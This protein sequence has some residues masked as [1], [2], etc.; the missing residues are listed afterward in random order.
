MTIPAT[1]LKPGVKLYDHAATSFPAHRRIY[2]L[3]ALPKDGNL[4][5]VHVA[6]GSHRTVAVTSP[7]LELV[8]DLPDLA[9]NLDCLVGEHISLRLDSGST[10]SGYCT[11]IHY[12]ST[13]VLGVEQ[14]QVESVELDHSGSSTFPWPTILEC[15][16]R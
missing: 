4:E 2:K 8:P 9:G 11:G 16:I 7:G 10:V 3:S 14:R 5:L 1:L 15:K 13:K 6:S 12:H